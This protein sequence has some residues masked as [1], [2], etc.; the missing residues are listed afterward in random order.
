MRKLV[1]IRTIAEVV[2][3]DGADQIEVVKLDGWQCVAKKNEFKAGDMAV[4]HEIDSFLP[5]HPR[6]NF[7]AVRG[8]Q[9]NGDGRNGYRLRTIRL[10]GQL[11]QGLALPLSLFPELQD[12]IPEDL[13]ELLGISK[14]EPAIPAQ[15]AGQAKGIFPSFLKKTDQERIQNMKWI[16]D[17]HDSLWEVTQ[18]LDG[19]SMSVF[20]NAGEFGVCSRN[21][22]LKETE[23]NTF[24][25]VANRLCLREKL[26]QIGENICLQGELI[27]PGIQGNPHKLSQPEFFLFDIWLI[28]EQRYASPSERTLYMLRNE[29]SEI[30]QAPLLHSAFSLSQFGKSPEAIIA[31]PLHDALEFANKAPDMLNPKNPAPEGV[32]FKRHDGCHSF[33]IISNKYLLREK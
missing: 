10:R 21:L 16:L 2:P 18:K 30:S 13:S 25:Q 12:H 8:I 6:Y 15:L 7:M 32:V 14:Y 17:D 22:E 29:L 20:W 11:S 23:G 31:G 4:Y 19:S 1:T 9:T 27:G 28:D 26:A 3:I 5:Q 33:K 24:W